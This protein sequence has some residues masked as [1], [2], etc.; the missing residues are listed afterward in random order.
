M[1]EPLSLKEISDRLEGKI[2]QGSPDSIVSGT[3]AADF[4]TSKG[5]S[6]ASGIVNGM[7]SVGAIIAVVSVSRSI[8]VNLGIMQSTGVSA[9]ACIS[10]DRLDF[11][12][13]NIY[14]G[15]F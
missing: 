7:G 10:E 5:A 1:T 14:K 11:F 2:L 3:A 9:S 13:F 4:G 6:T 12:I 15:L 8:S